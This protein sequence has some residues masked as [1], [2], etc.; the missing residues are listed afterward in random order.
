MFGIIKELLRP[1]LLDA[2]LHKTKIVFAF[3]AI[4]VVAIVM[5]LQA[6]RIFSSYT[7]VF[8]EERNVLGRLMEGA[9]VQTRVEDR[10]L[11]AREIIYGRDIMTEILEDFELLPEGAGPSVLEEKIE[12]LRG[13]TKI[14]SVGARNANL[15]K[16]EY[17]DKDPE[18][19]YLITQAL[20]E[21]FIAES[22]S[23]QLRESESAFSFIEQQVED[24]E[25][26]LKQSEE[27]LKNFRAANESVRP[28]SEADVRQ[29]VTMLR[30][31]AASIRQEIQ[32][33]RIKERSI[34]GQMA[35]EKK[36]VRSA[37]RLQQ[38]NSRKQALE[39]ELDAMR[40]SYF[41]T[42]PGIVR[43]KTQIDEID[44]EIARESGGSTTSGA[45]SS[46]PAGF[47]TVSDQLR[48]ELYDTRV[49]IST[50]SSRLRDTENQLE[51]EVIRGQE[52]P[53]AE[54]KLA[55]LTRDYEVTK[56]IYEDLLRRREMARVSVNVDREQKGLNLRIDEPAFMPYTPSGF[57]LWHAL[58]GGLLLGAILPFGIIFGL[59]QVDGRV[60]LGEQISEDLGLSLVG[61]I[62]RYV[63][64]TDRRVQ[65]AQ[66]GVNVLLVGATLVLAA[67]AGAARLNG[68]L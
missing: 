37:S 64:T 44:A 2:S 66:K 59:Q 53:D 11:I 25:T 17:R 31:Q 1:V 29:R 5:G 28:G 61:S 15:I 67:G 46:E 43:L 4:N 10:A 52:I 62:P 19:A 42:Y 56:G 13:R 38:L 36:T 21:R 55:N 54:A 49:I 58:A 8:V 22:K 23:E 18:R 45:D 60:R 57:R 35:G 51:A 14:S 6:P 27:E 9:A 16:I 20:G 39:N 63:N 50:L 30:A 40:L 48:K 7:T 12:A 34:V 3:V 24:Y 32:E 33:A 68:I 26:K 47:A 65:T 41:D